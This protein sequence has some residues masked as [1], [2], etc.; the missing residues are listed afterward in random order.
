MELGSI[1]SI[2]LLNNLKVL[3]NVKSIEQGPMIFLSN[4]SMNISFLSIYS[5]I[6]LSDSIIRYHHGDIFIGIS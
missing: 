4:G 1:E 6:S 3:P 2:S 5:R